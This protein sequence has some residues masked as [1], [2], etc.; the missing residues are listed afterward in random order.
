MKFLLATIVCTAALCTAADTSANPTFTKDIAPILYERC[1]NCHRSGDIAPMSLLTYEQVRP[2]SAAIKQSVTQ[3]RMPPWFA[4]PHYG[5]FRND[6]RLT[7]TQIATV[8]TWV[9]AGSPKGDDKDMPPLPSFTEGWSFNR[10]PDLIIEMPL[11]VKVQAKGVLD[12]QNYYVKVPFT[13]ETFVEAVELRPGNR[14]VVHHSIVNIAEIP[15]ALEPKALLTGE[16]HGRILWKLIG[17]APGKGAESHWPGV[18]KRIMPGTYFEFNMHYTPTGKEETDRTKMGIWFS[19]EKIHHEVITTLAASEIY[20]EGKLIA[21]ADLPNIPANDDNW[22]IVGVMRVPDD[23]TIYSLSPHMHFR[24]KDMQYSVKYPD[25]R[26]EVLLNVPKYNYEWQLNYEFASPPKI[27]A[28]SVITVRAHYDNSPN[29]PKNPT[30]D[31]EVVWGQQSWNEMFVPWI[32]YSVDKNNLL[33][34]PRAA[35]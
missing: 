11:E 3:R 5:K 10:P 16:K 27:P 23:I 17:Q 2:W 35:R 28:G 13:E 33:A 14:R 32:E 22:P 4:D 7:E 9:N 30:P 34:S 18:A 31:Q 24:G 12:L 20:R 8:T 19:K 25:G 29:N 6:R 1:A 21:R 26:D 15:E